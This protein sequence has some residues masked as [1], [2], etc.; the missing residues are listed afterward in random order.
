MPM[1]HDE[2]RVA[3]YVPRWGPPAKVILIVKETKEQFFPVFVHSSAET[4]VPYCL[5]LT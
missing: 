2:E 3:F 4:Q 1:I 5:N